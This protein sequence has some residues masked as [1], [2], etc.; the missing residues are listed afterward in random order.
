[1]M[2]QLI[3]QLLAVIQQ[4]AARIAALEAHLQQRSSNSDRPP[5]SDPPYEKRTTRS[6]V[7][8]KLSAKPGHPG[9]RQAL[10]G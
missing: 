2:L 4:Q 8:G 1:M 10:L 7:Q 5:F 6:G 3:V 9:H